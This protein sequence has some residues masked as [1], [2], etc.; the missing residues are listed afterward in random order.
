MK[1]I[2]GR[3]NQDLITKGCVELEGKGEGNSD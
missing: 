2:L 1:K 3:M